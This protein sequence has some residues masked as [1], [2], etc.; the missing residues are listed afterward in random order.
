VDVYLLDPDADR[1]MNL[2]LAR[3]AEVD[4]LLE[5]F[6]GRPM[7]D[8]WSP[9][10]VEIIH[11]SRHEGRPACDFPLLFGPVPVLSERAAGALGELIEKHGELLPLRCDEGRYYAVNV[12]RVVDA[13]DESRSELKRFRSGRIMRVLRYEFRS[14]L[15]ACSRFRRWSGPTSTSQTTSVTPCESMSSPGWHGTGVSGPV[16]EATKFRRGLETPTA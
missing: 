8:S 16:T 5:R 1:Y 9:L 7:R 12:T 3:I 6:D 13:L 10:D 2:T 4:Q 15:R 14:G 11:D